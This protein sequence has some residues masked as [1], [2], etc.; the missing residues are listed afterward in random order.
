MKFPYGI[1]DF[2]KVVTQ[3]YFYADRTDRMA[4]LE[5]AGDHVLFLRPRRFGKSLVLS[6]LENYYDLARSDGFERL[7]GHLKIGQA[8]T[9]LRNRY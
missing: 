8:P 7:F 2:H 5:G 9:P 4:S 3:D 6:M 1:A